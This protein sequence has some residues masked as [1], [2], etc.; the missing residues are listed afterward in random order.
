MWGSEHNSLGDVRWLCSMMRWCTLA[1]SDS[2]LSSFQIIAHLVYG[3]IH[4]QTQTQ[5]DV[6]VGSH[7]PNL[8]MKHSS[9]VTMVTSH[10]ATILLAHHTSYFM[11]AKQGQKRDRG[12]KTDKKKKKTEGR[13]YKELDK[14]VQ[15]GKRGRATKKYQNRERNKKRK[16]ESTGY[17]SSS[18]LLLSTFLIAI[19]IYYVGGSDTAPR[20]CCRST[21]DFKQHFDTE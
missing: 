19:F 15:G 13:E 8:A 20:F 14:K 6:S 7:P 3:G 1:S 21:S 5:L 11:S 9:S 17:C 16:G 18:V 10:P 4:T 12:T 2:E